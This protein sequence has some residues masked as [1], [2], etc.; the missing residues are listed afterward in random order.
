MKTSSLYPL[1]FLALALIV[2]S[3][4]TTKAYRHQNGTVTVTQRGWHANDGSYWITGAN[5]GA[6]TPADNLSVFRKDSIGKRLP[7]VPAKCSGFIDASEANRIEIRLIEK[8]G[9]L[10]LQSWA[11]GRHKLVDEGTPKPFYHWLIP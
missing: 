1:A 11:N 7:A 4:A 2:T 8:K 5:P 3:C 9:S 10:L 6:I